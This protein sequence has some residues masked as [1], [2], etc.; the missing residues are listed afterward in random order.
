[1][2]RRVLILGSGP[3]GLTASI[4]AARGGLAPLVISGSLAGGQLMTTTDVENYPGFP[5]GVAGPGLIE[6][7]RRQA[8]RFGTSFVDRDATEVDFYARP[9]K[10]IAGDEAFHAHAVIIATGASPRWLDLPNERRLRGSGV[11]SCATCDGA[12]FRKKDVCVVGGGDTAVEEALYLSNLCREV[13]LIHRRN[14]LRAEAVMQERLRRHD[15]V[16]WRMDQIVVD[17]LGSNVV[18][19]VRVR[20]LT[21]GNEEDVPC[22]GLFIAIGQKPNTD[23]LGGQVELDARGYVTAYDHTQTS[24]RG[25][26]VAGDV[27]DY[28]YQQVVTAAASGCKAAIDAAR[29][30][31]LDLPEEVQRSP[32]PDETDRGIQPASRSASP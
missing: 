26:F 1:M 3:A 11:S 20:H 7:M 28:N 30:L 14:H 24:V 4:Y 29:Y 18:E 31:E 22:G 21:S 16:K 6:N 19:G 27:Y 15:N 25:I 8:E 23:F 13:T 32:L 10:V 9:F 17:V 5:E 12:F 2:V